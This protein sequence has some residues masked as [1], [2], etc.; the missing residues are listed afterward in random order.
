[1]EW[2]HPRQVAFLVL[3]MCHSSMSK[4]LSPPQSSQCHSNRVQP[5]GIAGFCGVEM[6]GFLCAMNLAPFVAAQRAFRRWHW[7]AAYFLRDCGSAG[8]GIVSLLAMPSTA[9]NAA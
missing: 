7:A 4:M 2:P 5:E 8:L 1:M 6:L 9:L 3:G